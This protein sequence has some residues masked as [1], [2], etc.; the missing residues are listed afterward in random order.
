MTIRDSYPIP[1]LG[2]LLNQ[3]QGCQFFTKINL[4]S[5]FN[6][7]RV[8]EGHEWKTA[9]RTPWGLYEYL[10]M[11]FGLANAPA[12]FQCF[13]QFV[14]REMLN[15][16]CF[17]YI[18]DILVFSKT[19]AEHQDHVSQVLQ[20]LQE[21]LLYASPE[22]CL[23]YL[24]QVTFL[25]FQILA[26]GIQMET[27]KLSTI[28][29]WLYPQNLRE[30]N[31]FLGFLNFYRKFIRAFSEVAAPLTDLT[32]ESADTTTGLLRAESRSAFDRLKACFTPAPLLS[33]IDFAKPRIL[34]VDSSKYALS[35]VLSQRNVQ[36]KIWQVLFLSKK[37]SEKE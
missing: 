7:L 22:K 10:V 1:I 8:A 36:G 29:D 37:W 16:T 28:L 23:F 27:S 17:V 13:I 20:K 33:H 35:A 5:A 21:N 12:C 9:F 31:R 11:P 14:L 4:K 30:L 3:L 19:R 32:K 15:P 26:N 6:L 2:Q 34:Y 25:G 18:N 24:D